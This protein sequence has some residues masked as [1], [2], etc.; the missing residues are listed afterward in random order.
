[1][2]LPDVGVSGAASQRESL[3]EEPHN[4]F[5]QHL[6]RA[7]QPFAKIGLGLFG[8]GRAE[9]GMEALEGRLHESPNPTS[10]LRGLCFSELVDVH[11]DC[12]TSDAASLQLDTAAGTMHMLPLPRVLLGSGGS[13]RQL[14]VEGLRAAAK[15]S[16]G[17]GTAS[18]KALRAALRSESMN[19]GA[20]S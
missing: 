16:G 5:E 13:L 7:F 8:A 15:R 20:S 2:A 4:F 17:D 3:K 18:W 19:A 9:A 6:A 12:G 14:L 10:W 11:D 1:M